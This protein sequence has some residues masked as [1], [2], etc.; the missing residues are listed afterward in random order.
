MNHDIHILQWDVATQSHVII[1]SSTLG[2]N[3]NEVANAISDDGHYLI[4]VETIQ[5]SGQPF[6]IAFEVTSSFD[7]HELNDLGGDAKPITS[8]TPV[9]G[10]IDN[11]SDIDFFKYHTS[12][13][14]TAI[15]VYAHL[16][17]S[18]IMF[19]NSNGT[20]TEFLAAENPDD[21]MRIQLVLLPIPM[22]LSQLPRGV[23]KI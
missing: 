19:I 6:N 13:A 16:L 2:D 22:F 5:S 10:N 3:S 17:P 8:L 11:F 9:S 23:I 4:F 12:I 21:Q 1:A 18:Q 7:T 14:E 15:D 20:W